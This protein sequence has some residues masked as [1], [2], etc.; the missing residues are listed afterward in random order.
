MEGVHV[1]K[2]SSDL[3]ISTNTYALQTIPFHMLF[4]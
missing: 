3:A 1:Y 4:V 2:N